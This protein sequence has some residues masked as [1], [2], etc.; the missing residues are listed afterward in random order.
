M[1]NLFPYVQTM[2]K[3]NNPDN[4]LMNYIA[5]LLY[6]PQYFNFNL[7]KPEGLVHQSV[8]CKA[9]VIFCCQDKMI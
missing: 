6:I 7:K 2:H 3:H 4:N 5:N 8:I 1:T 9:V